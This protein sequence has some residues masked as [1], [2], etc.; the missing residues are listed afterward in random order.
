MRTLKIL[1]RFLVVG[2][3]LGAGIMFTW[4]NAE[5]VR[6]KFAYWQAPELTLAIV[7]L[8][9]FAL[10][11]LAAGLTFMFEVFRMKNQLRRSR[12]Q[13]DS[14]QEEVDTLRN[15]PLY[16][17]GSSPEVTLPSRSESDDS[18]THPALTT[19]NT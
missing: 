10:G 18:K 2:I 15:Q 12:K 17:E 1:Y 5:S 19:A 8:I 9:A 6:L 3:I 14:L 7:L 13:C 4:Q 11:V 16:E